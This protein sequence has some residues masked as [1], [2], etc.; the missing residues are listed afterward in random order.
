MVF[1]IHLEESLQ[2]MKVKVVIKKVEKTNQEKGEK[3]INRRKQENNR[4]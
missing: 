2:C 4:L 1:Q 3:K